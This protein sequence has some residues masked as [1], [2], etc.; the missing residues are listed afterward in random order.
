MKFEVGKDGGIKRI[1]SRFDIKIRK[2]IQKKKARKKTKKT[3]FHSGGFK[4]LSESRSHTLKQEVVSMM[5]DMH[6]EADKRLAEFMK[7]KS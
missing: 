3:H 2:K 7:V 4:A 1:K 5:G 6:K